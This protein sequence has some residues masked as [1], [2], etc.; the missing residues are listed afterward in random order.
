MRVVRSDR[1]SSFVSRHADAARPLDAW[2]TTAA[3]A[4]WRSLVD[5]RNTY[6]HADAVR[7]ASGKVVTI[8]NIKGNK[9]RLVAGIDYELGVVNVLDFLTHAEYSKD[10]WKDRL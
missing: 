7:V 9:Y 3:S 5:V 1:L 8:F 2:S 4:V 6:R 10:R